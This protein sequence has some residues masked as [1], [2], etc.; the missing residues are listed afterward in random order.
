[1]VHHCLDRTRFHAENVSVQDQ[2]LVDIVML[3]HVTW[4]I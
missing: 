3:K 1:M 2:E 4:M